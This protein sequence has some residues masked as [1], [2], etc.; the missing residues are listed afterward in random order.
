MRKQAPTVTSKIGYKK[1]GHVLIN[2]LQEKKQKQAQKPRYGEMY[3]FLVSPRRGEKFYK[4][5][6][7]AL[8]AARF[9]QVSRNGGGNQE[10]F[11][12]LQ[13]AMHGGCHVLRFDPFQP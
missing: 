7:T 8:Q 13:K 1:K 5:W 11:L 9:M 3:L 6:E 4:Q 10:S 12:G 2:S